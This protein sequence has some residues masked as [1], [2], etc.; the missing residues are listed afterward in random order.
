LPPLH[1]QLIHE[2]PSGLNY[3]AWD[4]GIERISLVGLHKVMTIDMA[5]WKNW[6]RA[7]AH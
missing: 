5:I 7:I 4:A 3:F 2:L 1:I 6:P